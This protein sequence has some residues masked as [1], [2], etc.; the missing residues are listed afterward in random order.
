MS[1]GE[2]VP[3]CYMTMKTTTKIGPFRWLFLRHSS[4][5]RNEFD[6]NSFPAIDTKVHLHILSRNVTS[7]NAVE[8]VRGQVARFLQMQLFLINFPIRLFISIIFT[9]FPN[10]IDTV[11]IRSRC[12]CPHDGDDDLKQYQLH[13]NCF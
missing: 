9:S 11:L 3:P 10:Y 12:S 2:D 13:R 1:V 6:L 4:F 8:H 7:Q 5:I